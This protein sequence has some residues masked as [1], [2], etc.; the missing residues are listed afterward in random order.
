MKEG[1]TWL[2]QIKEGEPGKFR[3][4]VSSDLVISDKRGRGLVSSDNRRR[5]LVSSVI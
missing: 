2:V 1:V 3:D 5:C 4:L